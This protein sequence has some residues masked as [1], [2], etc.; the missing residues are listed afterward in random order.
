MKYRS[1]IDVLEPK[2][3]GQAR[4]RAGPQQAALG[5]ER[6]IAA[7]D[8]IGPELERPFGD[9]PP[10]PSFLE[11]P[12]QKSVLGEWPAQRHRVDLKCRRIIG[13]SDDLALGRL[14][15]GEMQMQHRMAAPGEA[16]AEF[17]LERVTRIVAEDNTHRAS[18]LRGRSG[19]CAKLVSGG[20]AE[21]SLEIRDG[22]AEADF[23]WHLGFPAERRACPGDVGAALDRIVGR[24]RPIDDG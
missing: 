13:Q 17:D 12:A 2:D 7:D 1:R 8:E 21:Q 24:Q 6:H 3:E 18:G 9:Q 14:E 22:S 23:E 19:G 11:A 16:A 4:V 15:L 5:I 10:D 20:A